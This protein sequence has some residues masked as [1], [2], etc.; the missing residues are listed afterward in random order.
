MIYGTD[1]IF[2][3]LLLLLLDIFLNLSTVLSCGKERELLL[4]QK[5]ND[6]SLVVKEMEKTL[7][8]LANEDAINIFDTAKEGISSSTN[9]IKVLGLTQKRYYTRLRELMKVGLIEKYDGIYQHTI[10]G[11]LIYESV[12]SILRKVLANREGH[13]LMGKIQNSDLTPDAKK[14]VAESLIRTG[15]VD[16]VLAKDVIGPVKMLDNYNGLL[17][18]TVELVNNTK[19]SLFLVFSYADA[20]LIEALMK[21]YEREVKMKFIRE[22]CEHF[23]LP[24]AEIMTFAEKQADARM[25]GKDGENPTV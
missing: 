8:S 11:N 10:F 6:S 25:R 7:S 21:A 5:K 24:L 14:A 13:E 16:L 22:Y 19:D 4:H 20:D 17:E 9:T 1:A 18:K 23:G 2:T 12:V 3:L 15:T